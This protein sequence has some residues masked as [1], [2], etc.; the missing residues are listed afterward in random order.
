MASEHNDM[1]FYLAHEVANQL[2][3]RVYR[4]RTNSA[5]VQRTSSNYL[6]PDI[7]V[8]SDDS[9]RTKLGYPD[10]LELYEEPLYLVVEIWSRSTGAYDINTKIP[11]YRARGDL[12]IWRLHPYER[13]LTVWRRQADGSYEE[14]HYTGGSITVSSLPNVSIDLDALFDFA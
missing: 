1:T 9:F 2:D 12:E 7:C 4:V 8:L 13:T 14:A 3:R 10:R 5:H 6:I 11:E